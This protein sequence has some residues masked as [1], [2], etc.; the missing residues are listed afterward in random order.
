MIEVVELTQLFHSSL[1]AQVWFRVVGLE[2]DMLMSQS[3][4]V[5]QYSRLPS[6]GFWR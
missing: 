5:E 6:H 4:S 2:R 1:P 3:L